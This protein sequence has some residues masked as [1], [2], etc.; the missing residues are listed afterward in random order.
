MLQWRIWEDGTVL[1]YIHEDGTYYIQSLEHIERTHPEAREEI[2]DVDFSIRR[3]KLG[4]GQSIDLTGEQSYMRSAKTADTKKA[5]RKFRG[6]EL[7][8][9]IPFQVYIQS[10]FLLLH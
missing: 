5:F 1:G 4:I 2:E 6:F 3:N 10:I 7:L 9:K 8:M